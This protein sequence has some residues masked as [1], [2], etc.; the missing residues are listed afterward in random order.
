MNFRLYLGWYAKISKLPNFR[1]NF[2]KNI[3]DRKSTHSRKLLQTV[4]PDFLLYSLQIVYSLEIL[5]V[6]RIEENQSDVF[7][8]LQVS[9]LFVQVQQR[10]SVSEA[11][12]NFRA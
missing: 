5:K 6:S 9:F 11:W 12:T 7:E 2:E 10:V 3:R 4:L 1:K 8:D